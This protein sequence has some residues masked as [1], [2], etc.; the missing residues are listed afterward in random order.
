MKSIKSLFVLFAVLV[1]AIAVSAGAA[2]ANTAANTQIVN[3]AKLTYTGG[4][5]VAAPVIVTVSLVP[6]TP[7]VTIVAGASTAYSTTNS[8]KITDTVTVTATAN[9]P[10]DYTVT[11]NMGATNNTA[12]ASVSSGGTLSNL[13]A[14]VTTGT[15]GQTYVTVP[16][17]K[18]LNGGPNG[19]ASGANI[20]FTVNSHTYTVLNVTA[21]DNGDGTWKLSWLSSQLLLPV[22]DVPA[23]GVLV[24]EQRTFSVDALPGTVSTAGNPITVSV[25]ATVSTAGAA[26]AVTATAA[27]NTW[28][29]TAPSNPNVSIVKYVRNA[30][31]PVAGAGATP[32]TINSVASTYYTSGVTGKPGDILEYVIVASNTGAV[33]L[34]GSALSDQLPL[35]YVNFVP[36][37]YGAG[38]DVIYIDPGSVSSTLTAGAVGAGPASFVATSNPNL[39]VNVGT[40]ASSTT[41]G[42]IPAGKSVTIA[43]QATIR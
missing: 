18:I 4:S 16:A 3:S 1:A 22:A 9:G 33:D 10:A 13:G 8:P 21:A 29:T 17:G 12:G 7:N 42:T 37:A 32:F 23:V 14:S 36:N 26:D 39:V 27:L 41:T 15:S 30:T 19:L 2:F 28:T 20:T 40:G 11:P 43:Y 34:S 31:T 5:S 25:T 38:K 24:A 35:N 6:S